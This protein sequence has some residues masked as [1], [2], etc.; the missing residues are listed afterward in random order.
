MKN[1]KPNTELVCKQIE[2]L[3]VPRL[4]FSSTDHV[5]YAHLLRHT[6]FEG[7][8]RLRFSMAWLDR[9]TRLCDG[10]A[11]LGRL[12]SRTEDCWSLHREPICGSPLKMARSSASLTVM[13]PAN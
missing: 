4:R 3:L 12:E 5:V 10:A 11:P 6:R 13:H 1:K 8:L 2:D 7:K 9:G